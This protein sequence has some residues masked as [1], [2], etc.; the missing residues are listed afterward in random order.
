MNIL[1]TET[2]K[3]ITAADGKLI[4]DVADNSICR[5]VVLPARVTEDEIKAR[6]VEIDA[7]NFT[8]KDG[9]TYSKLA[10]RR[11]CR[12]LGIEY[13]LNGILNENGLFAA[14][15]ADAQEIDLSDPV[16]LEAL[17]AGT[18]TA[19]DIENIKAALG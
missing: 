11:A 7:D 4:K 18:F 9:Q 1:T 6:F 8:I 17:A 2:Y 13:K 19:D 14:D 12:E 5:K 3:E 15:W 16:L 10:I